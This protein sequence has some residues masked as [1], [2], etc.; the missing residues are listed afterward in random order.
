MGRI[1]KETIPP[2]FLHE[3]FG[4]YQGIWMPQMDRCWMS[5]DG[6]QVMS[7]LLR[8]KWGKVEHASIT[9]PCTLT[10]NGEND[11]PWKTKME[12]K[13]ELFGENRLAIE[14]FPKMRNLVDVM[15]VY[16]CLRA[17]AFEL[18]QGISFSE[19]AKDLNILNIIREEY[20]LILQLDNGIMLH[21]NRFLTNLFDHDGYHSCVEMYDNSGREILNVFFNKKYV[22]YDLGRNATIIPAEG[23]SLDFSD[24]DDVKIKEEFGSAKPVC[25]IFHKCRTRNL[26]YTV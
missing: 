18:N 3:N 24:I 7:R 13:N 8:T 14:V 6:I 25:L 5:N 12:I 26:H 2:I 17:I 4:I 19:A 15:D 21:K 16:D 11:L 9:V 1:W 10:S 22:V 23:L 20:N